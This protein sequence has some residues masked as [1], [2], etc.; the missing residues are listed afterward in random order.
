VQ[1]TR[2]K[3]KRRGNRKER[4][5]G[6]RERRP[7]MRRKRTSRHRLSITAVAHSRKMGMQAAVVAYSTYF[8]GIRLGILEENYEKLQ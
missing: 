4:P 5:R 1:R 6:E 8:P 3:V 2:Q 7:L